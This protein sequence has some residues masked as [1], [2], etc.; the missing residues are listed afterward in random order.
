MATKTIDFE[1]WL[2]KN[3]PEREDD[4]EYECGVCEGDGIIESEKYGSDGTKSDKYC[5]ACSGTGSMMY[6]EYEKQCE[7]D[8]ERLRKFLG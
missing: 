6:D 7:I 8:Q 3:Y 4:P 5:I 1:T 2:I